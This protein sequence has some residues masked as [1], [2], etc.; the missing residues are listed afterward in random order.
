MLS[1]TSRTAWNPYGGIFE[2]AE[3][4]E[5]LTEVTRELQQPAGRMWQG[6]AQSQSQ[7]RCGRGEPNTSPGAGCGSGSRA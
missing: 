7:G 3:K 2:Y 5:R 6:H 4:S 1:R